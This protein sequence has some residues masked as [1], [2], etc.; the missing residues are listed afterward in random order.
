MESPQKKT[1][2]E[3]STNG[4]GQWWVRVSQTALVVVKAKQIFL[5][6]LLQCQAS[7]ERAPKF[8][9]FLYLFMSNK[10]SICGV[11]IIYTYTT[12]YIYIY[13]H[14]YIHIYM[15]MYIYICVCV[16]VYICIYIYV[17]IYMY[18]YIY[19]CVYIYVY[20]YIYM[21][22]YIY[23]SGVVINSPTTGFLHG[24]SWFFFWNVHQL[25]VNPPFLDKL[26][27]IWRDELWELP[28]IV[29]SDPMNFGKNQ[30]ARLRRKTVMWLGNSW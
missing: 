18:I 3:S 13:L 29:T 21:C 24:V 27:L 14:M 1:Q 10:D 2:C 8:D 9:G 7:L 28:E 4:G 23:I 25:E 22:V 30:I 6:Q 20:I 17:Y 11:Y 15:C 16:C 5:R 26:R 19:M 12:I